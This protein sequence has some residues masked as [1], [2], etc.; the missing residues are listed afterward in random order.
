MLEISKAQGTVSMIAPVPRITQFQYHE[1]NENGK[2]ERIEFCYQ[3]T[4]ISTIL[5]NLT[6]KCLTLTVIYFLQGKGKAGWEQEGEQVEEEEDCI[7]G[8]Q[9]ANLDAH[10]AEWYLWNHT[11]SEYLPGWQTYCGRRTEI[12]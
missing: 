4:L 8:D 7:Y 11:V 2:K 12:N 5:Y 10:I 3:K 6:S 1:E 9:F